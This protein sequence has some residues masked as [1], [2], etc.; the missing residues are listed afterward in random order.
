M[1]IGAALISDKVAATI[2]AGDH[3]TTYGGNLLACR[4]ALVVLDELEGGLLAH[5]RR[6]SA[7]FFTGLA[8]LT[9]FDIVGAQAPAQA[10]TTPIFNWTGYYVGLHSGYR[11][12]SLNANIPTATPVFVR[13]CSRI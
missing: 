12:A 9:L 2:S 7:A 3:G 11:A 6:V 5:V 1:P 13:A 4:A 10:Q 8:A